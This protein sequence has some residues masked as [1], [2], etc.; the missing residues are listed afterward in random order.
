MSMAGRSSETPELSFP[1]F[2]FG[3]AGTLQCIT[4]GGTVHSGFQFSVGR[5][6]VKW[7]P[8]VNPQK[9]LMPPLHIKLGLMK[10]VTALHKESAPIKYLQGLFPKLSEAEIK[11]SVFAR[12]QINMILECKEFPKLTRK[13]KASW[14]SF[15]AVVQG[16]LSNHKAG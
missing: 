13:E 1:I 7:E 14:Y 3:R 8:L 4:T 11:A 12:L 6:S 5:N 9:A 15:V 2:I 16:F 10:L